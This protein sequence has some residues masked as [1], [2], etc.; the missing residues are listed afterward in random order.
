MK[1]EGGECWAGISSGGGALAWA[2]A[3]L[4][5]SLVRDRLLGVIAVLSCLHLSI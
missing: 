4:S 2:A 3:G 1:Y 5:V